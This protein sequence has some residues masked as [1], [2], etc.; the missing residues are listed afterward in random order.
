MPRHRVAACLGSALLA[1]GCAERVDA[2]PNLLL[3]T[4]D[5][6]RA[7]RLACYGGAADVGR[8]ICALAKN[9]TRFR[10]AFSTASATAPAIASVLTGRYPSFHAVTQS[11]YSTLAFSAV[12]VAELLKDHGYT[13]GA[14]VSNITL[15]HGRNF[16]QGFDVYD[17][18]MNRAE[19]NRPYILE[20]AARP[21]SDAALGWAQVHAREPW[22]LW[23]HF[24]DPH[25]PYEPP[26]A[27]PERDD[28]GAERLAV[29][30]ETSGLGGIPGYQI[31]PGLVTRGP[32]ERRYEAE[33][34]YL[35]PEVKRLVDGLDALGRPP[36]VLLTA[37]HGES[38]GEDR[39]YFAHGHS[40]GLDQVRIPM[41]WRPPRP[42]LSIVVDTP[43]SLVDIAPTLVGLA[44]VP[45]PESFQG[46]PLPLRGGGDP[47][48][49]VFLDHEQRA[50]V[51]LGH[52]YYARDRRPRV[53]PSQIPART[54]RLRGDGPLPP[55]APAD[56]DSAEQLEATLGAFL[57]QPRDLERAE[58]ERV[59]DETRDALRALGYVE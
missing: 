33:I 27:A 7:D 23:V 29:L 37:D 28:P 35:D 30:E 1:W 19:R 53:A 31:L 6:L 58:R 5:T 21:T 11:M 46:K 15:E 22:F 8:A 32:Y 59:T 52:D 16:W 36:A 26:G 50:G 55:Y 49:P 13:T 48:R 43:V 9:G 54:A 18:S 34:R 41:L 12:T 20:R 44:G 38:F 3:V 56:G 40:V 45:L 24:Q 14:F 47:R 57:E 39:Y 2:P 42:G 25:G 10:W 4:I 17:A 51:V